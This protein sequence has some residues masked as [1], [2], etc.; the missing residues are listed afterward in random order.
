[1][2]F[3]KDGVRCPGAL[4]Q[5]K[6][7]IVSKSVSEKAIGRRRFLKRA[8]AARQG[9]PDPQQAEQKRRV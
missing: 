2:A 8:T 4:R 5:T 1:M 7:R 9:Y 3:G 6:G